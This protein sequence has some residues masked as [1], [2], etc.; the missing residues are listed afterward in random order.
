MGVFF[1]VLGGFLFFF[2]CACFVLFNSREE[3]EQTKTDGSEDQ[4]TDVPH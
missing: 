4:E 2:K 1:V 3:E